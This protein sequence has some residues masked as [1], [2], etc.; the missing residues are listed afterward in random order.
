MARKGLELSPDKL[1]IISLSEVSRVLARQRRARFSFEGSRALARKKQARGE[2]HED[3]IFLL[4]S[5]FLHEV[6]AIEEL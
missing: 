2:K 6:L 5:F 4:K 1:V 3:S